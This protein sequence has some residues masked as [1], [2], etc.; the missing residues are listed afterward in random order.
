MFRTGDIIKIKRSDVLGDEIR[1]Q[2]PGDDCNLL[3]GVIVGHHPNLRLDM[4]AVK[5]AWPS[6]GF[7]RDFGHT[8]GGM[9]PIHDGRWVLEKD[10][11]SL[12][13][14]EMGSASV[15]AAYYNE[16]ISLEDI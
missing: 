14:L 9:L 5:L 15:A 3:E 16:L 11:I 12:S 10:M 8:C 6:D 2:C 1:I 4:W 13:H 7:L